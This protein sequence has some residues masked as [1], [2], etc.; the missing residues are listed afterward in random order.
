VLCGGIVKSD[1]IL[2]E[3]AL[4]PG[5]INRAFVEAAACDL[6]FAVGSTLAVMPANQVVARAR[7]EGA[8]VVIVNGDPTEMDHLAH[9]VIRGRITQTLGAIVAA[10]R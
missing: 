5:V 6:L 1:A 9:L 4:E 3:Q 8:K 7:A 2:F 10:A